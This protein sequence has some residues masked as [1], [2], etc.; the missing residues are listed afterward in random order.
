[1]DG[2]ERHGYESTKR[3]GQSRRLDQEGLNPRKPG[4]KKLDLVAQ[5]PVDKRDW[6][7]GE[8]KKDWDELGTNFLR[9]TGVSLFKQLHL[10]AE[11][12]L[13]ENGTVALRDMARFFAFYSGGRGF[14]AIELRSTQK[15]NY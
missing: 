13:Q 1:M 7:V 12:R 9:E 3:N 15:S 5:D 2:G 4:G 11:H 14:K 6:L 10:I 8:A